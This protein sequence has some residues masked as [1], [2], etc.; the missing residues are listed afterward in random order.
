MTIG[1]F[2]S[3][4]GGL[5]VLHHALKILPRENFIFYADEDNVPYG[6]KSREQVLNLVDSAFKFLTAQNVDAIVV[7]CNTATSVAVRAMR[8]KYSLPIVGMEPA[9]KKALDLFPNKKILVAGTEITISGEKIYKLIETLNAEKFS[10][11]KAL[12]KLVEFAERQEFN[13]SQVENYLRGEFEP[14][15]F[16][17]FSSIV[18]GC[19][20]FNYFKDTIKKILPE[21]MK[22]IDG[23]EGT[24]KQLIR[25]LNLKVESPQKNKIPRVEYFYSCRKVSS[26]EELERIENFLKRLDEMYFI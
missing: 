2:D 19:T 22:I 13:S 4:I 21:H 12:P 20:H 5:S 1:F 17:N 15:D 16:K 11:L 6:T 9:I 24:L 3:G 23:N 18:L 8:E 10:E 7:A 25:L 14:Y 26:P